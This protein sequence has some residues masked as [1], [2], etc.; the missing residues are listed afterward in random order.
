[1][2]EDGIPGWLEKESGEA[3]SFQCL[4]KPAAISIPL[5]ELKTRKQGSNISTCEYDNKLKGSL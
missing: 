5:N 1:M 2:L 3:K 4:I